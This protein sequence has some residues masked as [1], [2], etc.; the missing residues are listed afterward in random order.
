MARNYYLLLAVTF[1]V[2]IAVGSLISVKNIGPPQ[3][4][5]FDKIVHFG[6]YFV[7]ALSWFLTFNGKRRLLKQFVA[8]AMLVFL[9]G[10]IIE[11]CQWLFTNERQGDILDMLANLG[12]IS[13]ALLIFIL[14]LKKNK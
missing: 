8:I 6:G 12:G 1:T 4:H 14:F 9:Y 13:I 5:F 3:V 2:A 11:V 7:L 10:I